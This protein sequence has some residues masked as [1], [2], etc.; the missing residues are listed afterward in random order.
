MLDT[1]NPNVGLQAAFDARVI[2]VLIKYEEYKRKQ[3]LN[4]GIC[5]VSGL[6]IGYAYARLT[7]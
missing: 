5:V 4:F 1:E 7:F 3:Y 2:S 6:F